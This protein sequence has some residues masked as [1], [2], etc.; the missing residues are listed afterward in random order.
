LF[1]YEILT[2]AS[3]LYFIFYFLP[4]ALSNFFNLCKKY[5]LKKLFFPTLFLS[6]GTSQTWSNEAFIL[7]IPSILLTDSFEPISKPGLTY[8]VLGNTSSLQTI[9]VFLRFFLRTINPFSK[10]PFFFFF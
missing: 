8:F 6:I 1:F 9:F 10:F 7:N 2:H 3:L 4:G 5:K